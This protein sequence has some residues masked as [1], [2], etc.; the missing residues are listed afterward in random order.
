MIEYKDRAFPKYVWQ[1]LNKNLA[2][3]AASLKP[4]LGITNPPKGSNDN[5]TLC[6]YNR[7]AYGLDSFGAGGNQSKWAIIGDEVDPTDYLNFKLVGGCVNSKG[8]NRTYPNITVNS[9]TLTYKN[10]G[11]GLTPA[12]Y[13]D[14]INGI[15]K[16]NG[17]YTTIS[18]ANSN[19][20]GYHPGAPGFV[21]DFCPTD[22]FT[23]Y[24][25]ETGQ[26]GSGLLY[27]VYY[28]LTAQSGL[29]LG[30]YYGNANGIDPFNASTYSDELAIAFSNSLSSKPW[31][32]LTSPI[33]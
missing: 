6:S 29:Y 18:G 24:F 31:W 32:P 2:R 19:P 14:F 13:V 26:I 25:L 23:L 1:F 4:Y 20:G 21:A 10:Y 15:L 9:Q 3:L 11:Y 7:W 17:I 5:I 22:S 28:I 27:P 16:E 8:L 30:D 33:Q 12:N